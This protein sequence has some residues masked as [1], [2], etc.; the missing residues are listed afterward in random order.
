MLMTST[1]LYFSQDYK[2]YAYDLD[3]APHAS[4]IS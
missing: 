4:R 1:S 2:I 3:L